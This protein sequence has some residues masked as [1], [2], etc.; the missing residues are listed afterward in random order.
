MSGAFRG[1]CRALRPRARPDPPRRRGRLPCVRRSRLHLPV[2]RAR[3]ARLPRLRGPREPRH[4]RRG[5]RG[6]CAPLL[7]AHGS[8]DHQGTAGRDRGRP[9]RASLPADAGP[10][11]ARDG[12]HRI[13]PGRDRALPA[14]L[15]RVDT[16]HPSSPRG[17]CRPPAPAA[18][19]RGDG[20]VLPRARPSVQGRLVQRRHQARARARRDSPAPAPPASGGRE[21]PARARLRATESA[22]RAR[23]GPPRAALLYRRNQ[24]R[25]PRPR[26]PGGAHIRHAAARGDGRVRAVANRERRPRAGGASPPPGDRLAGRRKKVQDLLVDAKVP[27][28]ERD[29]WPLVVSGDEVVAVPG[30][31]EAPGWE[32]AVRA[33]KDTES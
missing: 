5:V 8:R 33:W 9:A 22:A 10:R 16:R 23:G 24:E 21:E 28:D 31:A 18:L 1:A 11:P 3:G 26:H 29:A 4:A 25:R 17:R 27:R 32:G 7:R 15:V 19:A 2:A 30:I 13:G 6:G 12:P 20:G 14:R